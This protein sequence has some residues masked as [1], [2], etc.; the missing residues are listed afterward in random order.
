MEILREDWVK[1]LNEGGFRAGVDYPIS[2]FYKEI[3]R[4]FPDV[5]VSYIAL[6]KFQPAIQ[7]WSWYTHL[8]QIE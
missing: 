5:K 6:G 7:D 4:A 2:L 8:W 1:L 3:F